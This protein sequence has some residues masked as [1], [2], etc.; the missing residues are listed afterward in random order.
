MATIFTEPL[1]DKI[2]YTQWAQLIQKTTFEAGGFIALGLTN[3]TSTGASQVALGSRVEVGGSLYSCTANETISGSPTA[4]VMNYVYCVP[5]GSAASFIYSSTTPTWNAVKGG[6]YNGNNRAVAQFYYYG[7]QYLSKVILDSYVARTDFDIYS[8]PIPTTGGTQV[9]GISGTKARNTY[10]LAAG[11]YRYSLSSG[12]GAGN[13]SGTTGG[14]AS[15]RDTTAGT[16]YWKGGEIQVRTGGDGF[17]GGNSGGGTA[18]A[19]GSGAGEESEIV[20]IAKTERVKAGKS[21][22]GN[23]EGIG[24]DGVFVSSPEGGGLKSC[25]GDGGGYGFGGGGNGSAD[26]GGG[27]GAG[28]RGGLPVTLLGVRGGDSNY[29][30]DGGNGTQGSYGASGGAGGAPGWQ[31]PVGGPGGSCTIWKVL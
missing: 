8:I 11:A 5:A 22:D 31:R 21:S 4:N 28:G 26:S 24:G 12:A 10:T 7:G 23:E 29:G 17:K 16:F 1:N 9:V 15:T 20:G 14:T 3:M 2:T 6:W 25:G 18:G 19:G 30:S 13:A 27:G